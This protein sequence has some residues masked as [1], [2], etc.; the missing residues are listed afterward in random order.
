M[1]SKLASTMTEM[2]IVSA[3]LRKCLLKSKKQRSD[4]QLWAHA[5][6]PHFT[7]R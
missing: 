6:L 3:P 1:S 2:Y 4:P 5:C 7:V